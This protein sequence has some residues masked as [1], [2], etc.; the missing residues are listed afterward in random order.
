[1]GESSFVSCGGEDEE[2]SSVNPEPTQTLQCYTEPS[3]IL[4]MSDGLA[5]NWTYGSDTKYFY[6]ETFTQDEYNKLSESEIIKRVVTNDTDDRIT[7]D[8]DDLACVYNC[9]ESTSYVIVTISFSEGDKQGDIVKTPMTTKSTKNQPSAT[10]NDV[11]YYTSSGNTYYGWTAKK[12]NYCKQYYTYAAASPD[13]FYSYYMMDSGYTPMIAWEI[14]NE[15]TKNG[16]D[17]ST[18]INETIGRQEQG[19]PGRDLHDPGVPS[20]GPDHPAAGLDRA[21]G[22]DRDLLRPRFHQAGGAREA[23]AGGGA[24]G[25]GGARPAGP[26]GPAAA[27][28]HPQRG[29][30]CGQP[31]QGR[32]FQESFRSVRRSPGAAAQAR[33][34]EARRA[35][36]E[37]VR[38]GRRS[39]PAAGGGGPVGTGAGL[40]GAVGH[41]L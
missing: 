30:R 10:I 32:P 14:R 3:N 7:P 22:L 33:R 24:P 11:S 8:Y 36:A 27:A 38:R 18:G 12:N 31:P 15:I 40:Q 21:C 41:F 25:A 9:K 1:M 17:H 13:I 35:G 28:E 39:R 37:S 20:V 34:V 19:R 23:A 26:A 29:G 4:L 6:W 16:E 2:E 5:F